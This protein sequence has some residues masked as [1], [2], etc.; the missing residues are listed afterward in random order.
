MR[1]GLPTALL[2]T[3][4]LLAVNHARG[5]PDQTAVAGD[6]RP[7]DLL[8]AEYPSLKIELPETRSLIAMGSDSSIIALALCASEF[9]PDLPR[10][11]IEI[12]LPVSPVAA[13][14]LGES[15]VIILY[16]QHA[17]KS[18]TFVRGADLFAS[19]LN[20]PERED[21]DCPW[22]SVD[23]PIEDCGEAIVVPFRVDTDGTATSGFEPELIGG[24]GSMV[25]FAGPATDCGDSPDCAESLLYLLPNSHTTASAVVEVATALD[26]RLQP[27][28]LGLPIRVQLTRSS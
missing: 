18:A 26:T 17:G 5:L 3:V 27:F 15:A 23:F 12:G 4:G 2:A 28:D 1:V 13:V 16:P 6:C 21:D 22:E 8:H 9:T 19:F 11:E 24:D 7:A 10:L 14:Q 25:V 20:H